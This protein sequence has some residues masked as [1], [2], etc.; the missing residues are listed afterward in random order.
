MIGGEKYTCYKKY[1]CQEKILD[2]LIGVLYYTRGCK[3]K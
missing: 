2:I 3:A 1:V